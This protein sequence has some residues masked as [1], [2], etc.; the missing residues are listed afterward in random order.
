MRPKRNANG[1]QQLKEESD[2][3]NLLSL[4]YDCELL[5]NLTPAKE[6]ELAETPESYTFPKEETSLSEVHP[7][8]VQ[9]L[10]NDQIF[11]NLIEQI[12]RHQSNISRD[13]PRQV[14]R[15]AERCIRLPRID[16]NISQNND[17]GDNYDL[18][19]ISAPAAT[20]LTLSELC[21]QNSFVNSNV[22]SQLSYNNSPVSSDSVSDS[23][24]SLAT[25][26]NTAEL[27]ITSEENSQQRS[28]STDPEVLEPS[29]KTGFN[30]HWPHKISRTLALTSCTLGLFNIS[31]FACLTINY[32]GN[33]LIQFLILSVVFGIPFLWLQMCLGAKIKSGPI[34]MWKISPICSG[35]GISLLF[36][37]LCFT[38]YSSVV[39]VWL[40]IYI[41]D[42]LIHQSSY[43][44]TDSI[45][46]P[47]SQHSS[48][49]F[50]NL[51]E[52]VPDYFNINVLQR[53]HILK[54]NDDN[55]VRLRINDR[56]SKKI[57][58]SKKEYNDLL[59]ILYL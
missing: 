8:S 54:I 28:S 7:N 34:S 39:V 32:G 15:R 27:N 12:E 48:Y 31:R 33:F 42:L 53:L 19:P 25:S 14:G 23:A 24:E 40:L 5:K 11:Q 49:I 21:S 16:N 1:K 52:S 26:N 10:S 43:P 47:N 45:R 22:S 29:I 56:V 37:Q 46:S 9:T 30:T 59:F 2:I 44:W 17:N 20:N 18:R 51:T 41:G 57:I 13:Q 58:R 36:A 3:T 35:I 4:N 38:I 6:L 55:S 50:N